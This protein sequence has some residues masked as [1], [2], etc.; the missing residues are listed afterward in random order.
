MAVVAS[1]CSKQSRQVEFEVRIDGGDKG[2]V[3][4]ETKASQDKGWKVL[5]IGIAW[6]WLLTSGT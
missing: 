4:E 2:G 1:L 6:F 5:G 3:G